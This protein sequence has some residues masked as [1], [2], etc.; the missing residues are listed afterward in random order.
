MLK[1]EIS[2]INFD[3]MSIFFFY[4]QTANRLCRE[5]CDASTSVGN[6]LKFGRMWMRWNHGKQ[7]HK[8][9]DKKPE[10]R[11]WGAKSIP[12]ILDPPIFEPYRDGLAWGNLDR[13]TDQGKQ[14]QRMRSS[15]Y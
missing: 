9:N 7:E 10:W 5:F 4:S 3:E 14:M 2:K 8:P 13:T 15:I 6:D 1:F 11:Y 12:S